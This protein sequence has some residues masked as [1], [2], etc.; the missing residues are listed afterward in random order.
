MK[1]QAFKD[2]SP[3]AN[4]KPDKLHE[5]F[6]PIYEVWSRKIRQEQ[7]QKKLAREK[8]AISANN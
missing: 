6:W 2:L 7:K 4:A 5:D 3:N 1:I 8:V